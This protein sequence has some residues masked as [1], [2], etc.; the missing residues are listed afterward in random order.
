MKP[1]WKTTEFW[2][3]LVA[4]TVATW[5]VAFGQEALAGIILSAVSA[6]GYTLSRGL[7]KTG[8]K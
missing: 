8:A 4:Q 2:V 6:L 7:A 3:T 1:G 5:L